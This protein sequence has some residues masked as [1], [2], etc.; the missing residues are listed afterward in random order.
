MLNE[1]SFMKEMNEAFHSIRRGSVQ[2]V[3][4]I[5]ITFPL[6]DDTTGEPIFSASGG[7]DDGF[8]FTPSIKLDVSSEMKAVAKSL[9]EKAEAQLDNQKSLLKDRMRDILLKAVAEV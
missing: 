9:R 1:D 6:N 2:K 4:S 5:T 8:N 7:Y 3:T